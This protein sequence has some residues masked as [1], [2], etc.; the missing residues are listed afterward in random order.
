[1]AASPVAAG[2]DFRHEALLYRGPGEFLEGVAP[3][4]ESGLVAGEEVLVVAPPERLDLLRRALGEP[5]RLHLRDM[6]EVGENP[7]RILSTWWRFRERHAAA[8]SRVRGVG[9]PVWTGRGVEETLEL[10]HHEAVL[11]VAFAGTAWPLLC[12]YDVSALEPVVVEHARRTHTAVLED[13][14][15]RPSARYPGAARLPSPLSGPL[16][17]APARHEQLVFDLEELARVRRF[18]EALAAVADLDGEQRP[19]VVLAVTELA[20]NSVRHGGGRGVLRTW[21]EPDRL[22]L[23]VRDR[24]TISDPLVGRRP[25]EPEREDGRGLWLAHQLCDLVQIRSTE[26]GTVVRIH[27]RRPRTG[28]EPP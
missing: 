3:F 7:G 16:P 17:R 13:G 20:A 22:V 12:P 23:E 18:V 2:T 9:E 11:N 1:M 26:D 4:A 5:E 8:G 24:G 19:G 27:V 21:Q 10:V 6:H 25:P 15:W 14:E 28:L